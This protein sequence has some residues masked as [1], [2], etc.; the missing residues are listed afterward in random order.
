MLYFFKIKE[1]RKKHMKIEERLKDLIV[2]KYGN[3][4]NFVREIGLPYST[5][6]SIMTRGI[7]NASIG[8]ILKICSAL[9]I[10][11]DELANGNI[12]PIAEKSEKIDIEKLLINYRLND[13]ISFELDGEQLSEKELRLLSDALEVSLGIIR[14]RRE[15]ESFVSAF[16]DK[17]SNVLS[18]LEE[19]KV[20]KNDSVIL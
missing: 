16:D 17:L 5:F 11:A 15:K 2:L 6:K 12:V 8:N 20:N 3:V 13:R 14:R 10:S 19:K 18:E 1:R 9:K 4:A 7:M